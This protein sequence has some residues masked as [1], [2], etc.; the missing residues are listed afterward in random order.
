LEKSRTSERI[1]GLQSKIL[2]RDL[3]KKKESKKERKKERNNGVIDR[4]VS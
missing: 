3:K 2:I 1:T 4:D